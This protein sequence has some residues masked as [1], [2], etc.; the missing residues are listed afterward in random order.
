MYCSY[1]WPCTL[2]TE[3]ELGCTCKAPQLQRVALLECLNYLLDSTAMVQHAWE[4]NG[5][6]RSTY[7][8][9]VYLHNTHLCT[10]SVRTCVVRHMNTH[11]QTNICTTHTQCRV[12]IHHTPTQAE[13][14]PSF[15]FSCCQNSCGLDCIWKVFPNERPFKQRRNGS[16]AKWKELGEW[17]FHSQAEKM[18]EQCVQIGK[19]QA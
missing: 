13:D 4:V 5:K 1:N 12:H 3:G 11:V 2:W 17:W 14:S 16:E 19:N 18:Q 8:H 15:V 6:W 7:A 9:T 10:H